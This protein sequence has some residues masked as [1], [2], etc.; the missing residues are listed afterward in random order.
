MEVARKRMIDWQFRVVDHY[1][2][3]R[4]AVAASTALLDRYVSSCHR[5]WLECDKSTF[6]LAAMTTL[7]MATKVQDQTRLLSVAKL[8]ELSRGEFQEVDILRM[9]SR[10]LV[11][12]GWRVHPVT[13]HSF[14]HSFLRFVRNDNALIMAALYD[15]AVFFAELCLFD[16][17]YATSSRAFLAAAAVLNALEGIGESEACEQAF[18]DA[19]EAQTDI[20]FRPFPSLEQVREDL[21][22]IYSLSAQYHEDDQSLSAVSPAPSM[23]CDASRDSETKAVIHHHHT[24]SPTSVHPWA[25]IGKF[26]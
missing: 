9:E 24:H 2:I 1:E 17:R 25:G 20:D 15:R 18:L 13:V 11:Q 7:Y 26:A 14:I 21:W 4:D 3:P 19:L 10:V 6:K 16:Q 22:Y 12:L 5:Q 23:T 8:V